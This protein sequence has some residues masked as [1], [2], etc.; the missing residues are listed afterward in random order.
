L[1]VDLNFIKGLIRTAN[2]LTQRTETAIRGVSHHEC[3]RDCLIG[4]GD[5]GKEECELR[6]AGSEES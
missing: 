1:D 6:I 4:K 5:Q 3:F 2:C